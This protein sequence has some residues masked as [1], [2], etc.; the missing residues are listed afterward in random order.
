MFTWFWNKSPGFHKV[1]IFSPGFEKITRCSPGFGKNHNDFTMLCFDRVLK[2][3]SGFHQVSEHSPGF[4]QDLFFLKH[5]GFTRFWKSHRVFTGLFCHQVLTK[6]TRF[7]T[8]CQ[9]F[10]RFI[11]FTRFWKNHPVFTRFILS[12]GFE[13]KHHVFT[14]FVFL[15]LVLKK[16]RYSPGLKN[17]PC[18]HQVYFFT[19]LRMHPRS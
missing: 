14:E 13:K 17:S 4:H 9:V 5:Q 11:C 16:S 12:P 18:F 19:N 15:H 3:S 7:W 10:T 8:N 6:T 1:Y 2:K